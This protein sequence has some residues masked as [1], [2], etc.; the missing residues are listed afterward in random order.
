M[1]AYTLLLSG[2]LL[3]AF[4]PTALRAQADGSNTFDELA[5]TAYREELIL[6]G[7]SA[8]QLL[9]AT[10]AWLYLHARQAENS[11]LL[12]DM[13]NGLFVGRYVLKLEAHKDLVER[14]AKT[15]IEFS[16]QLSA[17]AGRC[18]LRLDKFTETDALTAKPL[19]DLYLLSYEDWKRENTVSTSLASE[20]RRKA[21]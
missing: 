11:A 12:D 16:L 17:Q 7:K 4:C 9:N 19:K 6:P 3:L 13:Q 20:E 5:R 2:L 8:H 14:L 18:E 21:A 15:R 10:K 1:K